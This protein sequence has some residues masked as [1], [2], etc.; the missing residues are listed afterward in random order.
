M[1]APTNFT[2]SRRMRDEG[3]AV[4]F[5][6]LSLSSYQWLPEHP[7]PLDLVPGSWSADATGAMAGFEVWDSV[8]TPDGEPVHGTLAKSL[9]EGEVM[10]FGS[11]ALCRGQGPRPGRGSRH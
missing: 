4:P 11:P 8:T 5:G 2:P 10:H 3:L 6:W 7:C 1:G 9:H